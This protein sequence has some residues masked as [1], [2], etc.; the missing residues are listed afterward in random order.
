MKKVE[1]AEL[2]VVEAGDSSL[3]DAIR[4]SIAI[5]P[6]LYTLK[7]PDLVWKNNITFWL[8]FFG[9]IAI[10]CT[11]GVF[12]IALLVRGKYTD[13]DGNASMTYY[14]IIGLQFKK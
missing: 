2:R 4:D 14:P 10:G 3:W 5:G 1:M 6:T 13:G 9:K 11:K 8:P 12:G 7:D